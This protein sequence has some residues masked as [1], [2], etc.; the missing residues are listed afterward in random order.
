VFHGKSGT[1]NKVEI[2]L[3]EMDILKE[4]KITNWWVV[5]IFYNN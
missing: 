5:N 2:H 3:I 4:V 1:E